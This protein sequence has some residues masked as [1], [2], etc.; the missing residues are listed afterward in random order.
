M[1]YGSGREELK[2][3]DLD[4]VIEKDSFMRVISCVIQLAYQ[5][6]G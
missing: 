2:I 6:I 1:G 5:L 3:N 4:I